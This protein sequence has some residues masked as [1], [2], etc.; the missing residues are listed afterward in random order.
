MATVIELKKLD[1]KQVMAVRKELPEVADV[2]LFESC[3]D[4]EAL[5]KDG[6]CDIRPKLLGTIAGIAK[7]YHEAKLAPPV[8]LV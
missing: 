3:L 7:R 1:D 4:G 2:V 6:K 8:G 5:G